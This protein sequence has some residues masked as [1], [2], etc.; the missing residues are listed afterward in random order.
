MRHC[1]PV[2]VALCM[3][4]G[5]CA[6]PAT[7]KDTSTKHGNNLAGLQQA[8]GEYR[9]QLDGY[10]DRLIAEQREAHIAMHVNKAVETIASD[11]SESIATEIIK[12]P[13]SQKPAE[14]FIHAGASLADAFVFWGDNFDRWVEKTEGTTLADRRQSLLKQADELE[15]KAN[16]SAATNQ[17]EDLRKAAE[18]IRVQANRAD[19]ELTYVHVAI[20]LKQQR[21]FLDTQLEL[22]AA[23]VTTMQ[24]FH[25]KV[26]E[27][28]SI[29]A[30]IDGAKIAAAA[31]AGSKANTAGILAK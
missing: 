25:A 19:D 17:A 10:Y 7:V 28:L 16:Q 11:Q 22:L 14:D 12:K 1:F 13:T 8:V 27:F 29:D 5:G 24:A 23:Q 30:T 15:M 31:A 6:T 21:S 26:N 3:I 2:V 18:K 20:E 9:R 4:A